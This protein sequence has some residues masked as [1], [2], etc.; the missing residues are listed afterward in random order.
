MTE[1]ERLA[2][3]LA[4][5]WIDT[6][7]AEDYAPTVEK[8]LGL[9]EERWEASGDDEVLAIARRLYNERDER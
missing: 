9:D 3:W 5:G 1:D 2:V 4:R 6:Q 7:F 8:W